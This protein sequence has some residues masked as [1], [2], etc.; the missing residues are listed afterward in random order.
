MVPV[1][2]RKTNANRG[3]KKK[4]GTETA[5]SKGSSA[6]YKKAKKKK[7]RK[8][9]RGGWTRRKTGECWDKGQRTQGNLTGFGAGFL[10]RRKKRDRSERQYKQPQS[11]EGSGNATGS[12]TERLKKKKKD[13]T[14][15]R[16]VIFTLQERPRSPEK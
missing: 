2:N 12:F 8:K 14:G 7:K 16:G 6:H 11:A 15:R 3:E 4:K 1:T 5:I 13:Q 9:P 10:Q